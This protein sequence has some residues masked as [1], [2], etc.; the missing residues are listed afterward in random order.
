MTTQETDSIRLSPSAINTYYRSPRLFYYQYILKMKTPLNIHLYKGN[1][2]H[3]ILENLFSA[4]SFRDTQAYCNNE[5]KKWNPPEFIHKDMTPEER[6]LQVKEV[7]M[8]LTTFCNRLNQKI[9]MALVQGKAKDKHHAWNLIKPRMREQKIYDKER[10]IVGIIDSVETNF[11]KEVYVIDY[12]TSSLYKHTMATEYFRQISIYAYLY[13]KEHG[14]VPD[15]VGI[16]Y[17]RYGE[18]YMVPL[19]IGNLKDMVIEQAKNDID[20]VRAHTKSRNIEDYPKGTDDFA[21]RDIE[22][23]EKKLAQ[24][25]ESVEEIEDDIELDL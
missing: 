16:D 23:F 4:T 13:L 12:K 9:E 17:L 20:M 24:K 11:D 18:V 8:M 6:E 5:I 19:W 10:N 3:K 7:E 1:F 14:R 2:V 25:E 22:Y 21:L 15:Y